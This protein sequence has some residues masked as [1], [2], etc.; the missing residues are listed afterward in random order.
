MAAAALVCWKPLGRGGSYIENES[1]LSDVALEWMIAAAQAVP[2]SLKINPLGYFPPPPE[3]SMTKAEACCSALLARCV[4]QF[5]PM[6]P[7][8]IQSTTA[9]SFPPYYSMT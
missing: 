2:C 7:C 4:E 5:L 3:C 6:P 1:R 9:S 8:M